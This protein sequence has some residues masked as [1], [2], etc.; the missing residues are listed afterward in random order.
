[1]SILPHFFAPGL[2]L[3]DAP[4]SWDAW[5][6][7]VRGGAEAALPAIAASQTASGTPKT[8]DGAQSGLPWGSECSKGWVRDS[9]FGSGRVIKGTSRAKSRKN[10]VLN[11]WSNA[12]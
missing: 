11:D 6:R 2:R 1:M 9:R 8:P 7:V 5:A 3:L 12:R 10:R 4:M